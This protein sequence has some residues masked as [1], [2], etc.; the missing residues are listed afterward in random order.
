MKTAA[1]TWHILPNDANGNID[2]AIGWQSMSMA[3]LTWQ[4]T[5][6]RLS[7]GRADM[8]MHVAVG[9]N[10]KKAAITSVAGM[11]ASGMDLSERIRNHQPP[12]SG[13]RSTLNRQTLPPAHEMPRTA[14][15]SCG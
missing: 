10:A 3:I 6:N 9:D 5:G 11:K 2:M 13:R 15:I 4:S 1:S 8:V 14:G 12:E 7:N